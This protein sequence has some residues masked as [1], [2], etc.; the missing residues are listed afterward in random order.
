MT[1]SME[2]TL[3]YVTPFMDFQELNNG[4]QFSVAAFFHAAPA[5]AN[6][7]ILM[8]LRLLPNTTVYNNS[9]FFKQKKV[10]IRVAN[11]FLRFFI[12]NTGI[13]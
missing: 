12:I 7:N 11:F 8:R 9:T 5:L 6:V 13:I 1:I 4:K 10:N 2:H 3:L